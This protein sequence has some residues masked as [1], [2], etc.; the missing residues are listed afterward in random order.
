MTAIGSIAAPPHSGLTGYYAH[1]RS[2][3][4]DR[5]L[6][7][8]PEHNRRAVRGSAGRVFPGN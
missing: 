3:H 5:C 7:P 2:A 4:R 8:S 1:R 6:T